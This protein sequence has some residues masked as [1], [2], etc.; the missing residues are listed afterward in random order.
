VAADPNGNVCVTGFGTSF[1]SVKLS[2]NGAEVWQQSSSS[3]CGAVTSQKVVS[4]TKG[5]FY[6]TGAY[7]SFCERIF[8]VFRG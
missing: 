7:P 6:V 2:R 1:N 3:S 5:N 4:D 8:E